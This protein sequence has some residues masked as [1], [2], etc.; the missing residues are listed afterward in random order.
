MAKQ[1]TSM[2][3]DLLILVSDVRIVLNQ[4][5]SHSSLRLCSEVPLRVQQDPKVLLRMHFRRK[6]LPHMN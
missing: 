1:R 6:N 2:C 5:P 4:S 3:S